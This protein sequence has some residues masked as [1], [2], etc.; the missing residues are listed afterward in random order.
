MNNFFIDFTH[1]DDE[2]FENLKDY[3]DYYVISSKGYIILA[4]TDT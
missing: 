3:E 2:I 4:K 1:T